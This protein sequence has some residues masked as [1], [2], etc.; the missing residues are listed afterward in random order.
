MM[1]SIG[2]RMVKVFA[3]PLARGVGLQA[4]APLHKP[5]NVARDH[6]DLQVDRLPGLE[7]GRRWSPAV[8]GMMLT[9][10][11][12]PR[13]STSLTVSETPS[14][15]TEPFSAMA[16]PARIGRCD[17]DPVIIALRAIDSDLAD[18]VDVP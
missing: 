17:V 14:T 1:S 15:A 11:L 4:H 6:V 13:S 5:R 7:R 16:G 2:E 10:N 18:A 9:P 12:P 8:C 3:G